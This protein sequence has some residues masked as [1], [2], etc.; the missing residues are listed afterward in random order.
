MR[1]GE[2]RH[3]VEI[4]KPDDAGSG[5]GGARTWSTYANV[6]AEIIPMSGGETNDDDT[7]KKQANISHLIKTRFVRGLKPSMRIIFEGRKL[8]FKD[9]RNLKERNR[10]I[11]IDA[12]EETD[13]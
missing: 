12:R 10:D 4:Q 9:I 3:Y 1:A 13:V 6:W 7:K 5:W 8:K 11:E 2:L